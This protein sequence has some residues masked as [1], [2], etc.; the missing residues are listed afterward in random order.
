MTIFNTRFQFLAIIGA[1]IGGTSAAYFLNK[2]SGLGS[3]V[4]VFSKDEIGGRLA[5]IRVAGHE[6]ETGG[7]IL[8]PR[9]KYMQAF[10]EE[11][12]K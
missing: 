9:N 1:G 7:S 5:T 12:G 3:K 10:C 11:F 8:H 4:D 2:I 6:Y